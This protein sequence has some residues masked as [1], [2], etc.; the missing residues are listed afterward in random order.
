M[1]ISAE[2]ALDVDAKREVEDAANILL[3]VAPTML[4]QAEEQA[5]K[6]P[7]TP[8]PIVTSPH[9]NL[10]LLDTLAA[11]AAQKSP[12]HR[13]KIAWN[14]DMLVSQ[15]DGR[16]ASDRPPMRRPR[17]NSEPWSADTWS[18]TLSMAKM[19]NKFENG[20][21]LPYMLE[22]YADIYNKNGRIGIYTREERDNIIKRFHEK[23]KRRVWAKQ[24]RYHCRK[25]LAD[26]R[27]RVKGRFV[28]LAPGQ[29]EEDYLEQEFGASSTTTSTPRRKGGLAASL[30]DGNDAQTDGSSDG[31]FTSTSSA[32]RARKSRNAASGLPPKP[33]RASAR[34]NAG[35]RQDV[36]VEDD[37]SEQG[38]FIEPRGAPATAVDGSMV[39]LDGMP[40]KRMR[41]HSVAY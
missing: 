3:M 21:M 37:D 23:R 15:R 18:N 9:P 10:D 38:Q 25:N 27:I 40:Y 11:L 22:K 20:V 6:F 1:S 39:D 29:T 13:K 30:T 5:A 26:R 14:D 31:S 8:P 19:D 16:E 33:P 12:I 41:R 35:K 17:S 36:E 2:M 32:K 34:Q 4:K 24:I 7:K 28:K